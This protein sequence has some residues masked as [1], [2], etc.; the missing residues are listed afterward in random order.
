MAGTIFGLGLSQQQDADGDPLSGCKLYLYEAGTS[1][2]VTTYQD[3]ALTS[4]LEHPHPIVADAAGRI[5]AFWVADGSYRVRL[6]NANGT[7]IFDESSITALG[8]SNTTVVEGQGV[9][10]QALLQTGDMICTFNEG[11]R[12]GWVKMWGTIGNAASSATN[13]ANADTEALFAFLWDNVSDTYAA[14]SGGRGA[15]AA[16]D[17]AAAKAIAIPDMQGRSFI[18]LDDM[19]GNSPAAGVVAAALETGYSGGLETVS[20][21]EANLPSHTHGPGTLTVADHGHAAGTLTVDSHN[22]DVTNINNSGLVQVASGTTYQVYPF[23][24][25]YATRI[26]NGATAT[27]SGASA[28]SAPAVDA[29][30]TGATGSGTALASMNPYRAG[31]WYIKL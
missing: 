10:T 5:P 3:I 9:S 11:T 14:V 28:D 15:S 18:G 27:I 1:T 21:A 22:H 17:F 23:P 19:Q 8:S 30:V 7:E 13:R 31:T 4:G 12:T 16:A 20:I 26:T 6:T 2:P 25:G 24:S 29:G